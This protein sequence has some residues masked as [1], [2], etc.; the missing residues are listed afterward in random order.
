L[1]K[2]DEILLHEYDLLSV[3]NARLRTVLFSMKQFSRDSEEYRLG[4]SKAASWPIT[5]F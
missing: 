3:I 5:S 1:K 4:R 2:E